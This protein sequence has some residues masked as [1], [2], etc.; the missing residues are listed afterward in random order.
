MDQHELAE[1]LYDNHRSDYGD[2]EYAWGEAWDEAGEI[3]RRQNA[4][5]DAWDFD[6]DLYASI[7]RDN[8]NSNG[9]HSPSHRPTRNV[10]RKVVGDVAVNVLATVLAEVLVQA[11]Y[12]GIYWL[13][14]RF[15][16]DTE[17][18]PATTPAK[19]TA[20]EAHNA[21]MEQ[22]IRSTNSD[23]LFDAVRKDLN[24]HFEQPRSMFYMS[25][26]YPL[27]AL[28]DDHFGR[29]KDP[30]DFDLFIR[31][32]ERPKVLEMAALHKLLL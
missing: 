3:I 14:K 27:S 8:A 28:L 15:S 11:T 16:E 17:K 25:T 20:I 9:S 21:D 18:A 2:G 22:L 13:R 31:D 30:K 1:E 4:R 24:S 12:S 32:E 23:N 19:E 26:N 6:R 29:F 10:A 5:Q 7:E